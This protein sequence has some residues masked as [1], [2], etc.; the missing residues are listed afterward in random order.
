[1]PTLG[2]LLNI[3]NRKLISV[4]DGFELKKREWS[5]KLTPNGI[6]TL[7]LFHLKPNGELGDKCFSDFILYW[8][9]VVN[10]IRRCVNSTR[11]IEF[12]MRL[13]FGYNKQVDEEMYHGIV[14][15]EVLD[16]LIEISEKY[17]KEE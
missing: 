1:M 15:Q 11:H 8:D 9:E 7:S 2:E 12:D 14:S 5:D 3:G 10:E 4:P 6:V 17:L 13:S 16:E